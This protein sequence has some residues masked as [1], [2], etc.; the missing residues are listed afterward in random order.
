[1]S[2]P[3]SK[4]NL[5]F[6]S[7]SG[8]VLPYG[9]QSISEADIAA[10]VDVLRSDWLTTGPAVPVF[11]E[12]I[13]AFSGARYGVAV[14][15]G[16]AAL[17]AAVYA[18]GI[19]PGDEVIVP[20]ITFAA[21]ANAVV[22]QGGTPVFADVDPETL[23]LDPA[24]VEAA[25][26]PR[27]RAIIA[28]D[29]AG[30][31]C[32]YAALRDIAQ[33]H[34]LALIADACH[35]LGARYS[36][37]PVG[38][39]ADLTVFS[40]HPV[41]HITTGEGGMIVT[42]SATYR[43][44]MASFRNHGIDSDHRQRAERGSWFYEVQDLGYNYRITDFQCALGLSQL[45][46]LPEWLEGRHRIAATYS[47]AFEGNPFIAPLEVRSDVF[48]AWHLYVTR[49]D[50]ASLRIS[51][52]AAF[53]RFREQGIG[54]NVHYVPVHL[55][56]YYRRRWGTAPGLCPVAEAAYEELLSLPIFPGMTGADSE[57]V[58]SAVLGLTERY[59]P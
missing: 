42:G 51:R 38:S 22:F 46:R 6:A 14:S 43:N 16:T 13:A 53:S 36:G 3:L 28:V 41:K 19:G 10:V 26:T 20:P 57:R 25:I 48:H 32:D 56:P 2:Q 31:P 58:I 35:S 47:A 39:L 18:I 33:R 59:I 29:Y 5:R 21:T 12:R 44:R 50:F 11:E 1:M 17:H 55:H 34:G 45:S 49:I 37:Q 4:Q 24:A 23:L 15:S 8:R 54:V 52:A 30:Q 7:S 9:R 27:T 40:F